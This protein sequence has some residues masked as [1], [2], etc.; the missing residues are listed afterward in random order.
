MNKIIYD[1]FITGDKFKLKYSNLS[2]D[3]LF[4]KIDDVLNCENKNFKYVITHNGDLPVTDAK[5]HSFPKLIKWFGQNILSSN[6]KSI[7]IPIGLE[8]DYVLN[9]ENK[10][11]LILQLRNN[12]STPSNLIYCNFNID[13]NVEEDR[14]STRLNS[15]HRT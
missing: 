9:S 10:K 11:K 4:S 13:N 14:K 6:N 5:I 3:I 8:N 2:K 15:S 1:E 12:V 7:P